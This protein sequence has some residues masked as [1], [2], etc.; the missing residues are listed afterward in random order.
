MTTAFREATEKL[1][2]QES[3]FILRSLK[4]YLG[5]TEKILE[6]NNNLRPITEDRISLHRIEDTRPFF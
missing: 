4:R 3:F 2:D 6:K 5:V 1:R